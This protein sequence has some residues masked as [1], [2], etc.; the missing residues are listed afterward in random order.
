MLE[1]LKKASAKAQ[2]GNVRRTVTSLVETAEEVDSR[3]LQ[4]GSASPADQRRVTSLQKFLL[5]DL[6]G[7][8][9]IQDLKTEF[10]EPIMSDE[11]LSDGT[12]MAVRHVFDTAESRGG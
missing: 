7:P 11:A 10:M 1:W 3:I 12:K 5:G 8:V 9:T 6:V 2:R 4:Y